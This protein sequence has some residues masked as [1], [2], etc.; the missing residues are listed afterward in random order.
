MFP[1]PPLGIVLDS[2]L[3]RCIVLWCFV[4][5]P[6]I[7]GGVFHVVHAFYAFIA[8]TGVFFLLWLHSRVVCFDCIHGGVFMIWL[9][10][11]IKP[12][13]TQFLIY[14]L[15]TNSSYRL[16]RYSY[17]SQDWALNGMAHFHTAFRCWFR[18]FWWTFSVSE[19]EARIDFLILIINCQYRMMCTV[20]LCRR[21]KR[22]SNR[23]ESISNSSPYCSFC[24]FLLSICIF[25]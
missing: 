23:P 18:V 14:I 6:C 17:D 7:H 10:V 8:F 13:L 24:F 12:F 19:S 15:F 21:R 5:L 3:L 22:L 9:K 4:T 2:L 1:V 25:I 16:G 20:S 11:Y